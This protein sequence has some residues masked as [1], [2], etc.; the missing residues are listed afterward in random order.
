[1][2][3]SDGRL[4]RF[5]YGRFGFML[6]ALG[7]GPTFTGMEIGEE[8]FRVRFSWAFSA[9]IARSSIR[10]VNY[11]HDFVGGVG[12]HGRR[13]TWLVN[14]SATGLIALELDPPARAFVM[15]FPVK[16]KVLR[17][18]VVDPAQIIAELSRH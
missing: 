4:L 12:V 18:S 10:S 8:T 5:R 2:A 14:G 17:I 3:M 1:M 13:G 7:L 9:R 11:D 15:G 6:S 16:L